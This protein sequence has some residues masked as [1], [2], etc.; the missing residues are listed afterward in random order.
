[1]C[2]NF[3]GLKVGRVEISLGRIKDHSVNASVR[4][5]LV[6]LNI[7]IELTLLGDREDIAISS[8]FVERISVDVE[9]R[10]MSSQDENG[11]S[12]GV[13]AGGEGYSN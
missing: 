12:V 5:I 7:L 4:F 6:V 1:M 10:L 11:A 9:R 8:V 3:V 2:P 13:S